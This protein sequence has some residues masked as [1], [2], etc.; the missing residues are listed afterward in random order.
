MDGL[1][2]VW[3]LP[4]VFT[5]RPPFSEYPTHLIILKIMGGERPGRLQEGQE[6]GLTDSMWDV[7][8]RCWNQDPVQRPL[9]T[10]VVGLLRK[11]LVSSLFVEEDLSN[12]FQVRRTWGKVDQGEKA[13]EFADRLDEVRHTDRQKIKYLHHTSRFLTIQI[14]TNKGAGNI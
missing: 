11:L 5:G 12:F 7:V 3:I 14:S 10:E 1:P 2:D 8:V 9:M 13:Q 6:L 4:K